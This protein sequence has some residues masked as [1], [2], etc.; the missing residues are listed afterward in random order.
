MTYKAT[1]IHK[2][3][4]SLKGAPRALVTKG[5]AECFC[6]QRGRRGAR[7]LARIDHHRHNLIGISSDADLNELVGGNRKT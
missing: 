3:V 7:G 5:G 2:T 6:P 1:Q 4:L